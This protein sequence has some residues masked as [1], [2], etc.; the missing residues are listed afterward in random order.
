MIVPNV[1][2]LGGGYTGERVARQLLA[3]GAYVTITS[4]TPE[5]L[6]HLIPL[7][8]KLYRLDLAD[9][10]TLYNLT[11]IAPESN[12]V[13]YSIP[14]TPYQAFEPTKLVLS[15]LSDHIERLVYISTTSVYGE[16]QVVDEH[17]PAAPVLPAQKLR[18][19]AEQ[20]VLNSGASA[21]CL[22]PAGIYGPGRGVHERMRQGTFKLVE[23]GSN[24]LSRIHVD[25]LAT[26]CVAA[27]LNEQEIE[28]AYPVADEDSAPSREVAEF[29]ANLLNLPMPPSISQAEAH[30]T[31]RVHRQVDG[32]AIRRLL[33]ITL[34]YP[35][36][37]TGIPASL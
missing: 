31:L 20:A 3:Q 30:E 32:S 16:A 36:Y 8:A 27:L 17:T 10:A 35:S 9:W 34:K 23:A 13:L 33:G 11:K 14:T 28:G 24:V 1:L 37:K 19:E 7:G 22:R 4:R 29:C 6:A 18:I 12:Y 2:I 26:H 21:L 15:F 25:D 5:K